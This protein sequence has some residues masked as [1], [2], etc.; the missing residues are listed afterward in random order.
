MANGMKVNSDLGKRST[1][2]AK[3]IKQLSILLNS[4]AIP[5][6]RSSIKNEESDTLSMS[7]R[8]ETYGVQGNH[9]QV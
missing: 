8:N 9:H 3:A 2:K 1:S 7:S 6:L 4:F 5:N